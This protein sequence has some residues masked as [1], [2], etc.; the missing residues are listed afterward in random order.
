VSALWSRTA[1]V[2]PWRSLYC[3]CL[4]ES[5]R[6]VEEPSPWSR[7]R[8]HRAEVVPWCRRA[9]AVALIYLIANRIVYENTGNNSN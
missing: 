4:K 9:V 7:P 6:V 2:V 5:R 3:H 1:L 8:R